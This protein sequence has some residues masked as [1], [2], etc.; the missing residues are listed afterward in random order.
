MRDINDG[1]GQS[2]GPRA[3]RDSG[4]K[5]QLG[6]LPETVKVLEAPRLGMI[7][8][9]ITKMTMTQKSCSRLQCHEIAWF[10]LLQTR[11]K[12]WRN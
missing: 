1:L 6:L 8:R 9:K 10:I 11:L 12:F 4:Y 2:G 7:V 5:L 3:M